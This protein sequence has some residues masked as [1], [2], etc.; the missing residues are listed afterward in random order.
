MVPEEGNQRLCSGS[1]C[2][3]YICATTPPPEVM[4]QREFNELETTSRFWS[5][6]LTIVAVGKSFK[7]PR[8][9]VLS[10][11][12]QDCFENTLRLLTLLLF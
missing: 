3:Q 9:T 7:L 8:A 1:I 11:I 5:F 2:A 12:I 10:R 4:E 6:S